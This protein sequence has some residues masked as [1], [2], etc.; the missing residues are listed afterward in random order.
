MND[1]II[2]SEQQLYGFYSVN[3]EYFSLGSD[4]NFLQIMG[5]SDND[6]LS[7]NNLYLYHADEEK[8][9][10]ALD[11]CE[12]TNGSAKSVCG[13]SESE[14]EIQAD[15]SLQPQETG[16]IG[17]QFNYLWQ[18]GQFHLKSDTAE[19]H[20]LLGEI[21]YPEDEYEQLFAKN[22]YKAANPLTFYTDTALEQPAFTA[23]RNHTLNL[24]N[25]KVTDDQFYLQ[26]EKD[27]TTGWQR[28]NS[29]EY[30]YDFDS[31]LP[32]SETGWF[33]GVY[34]RLAG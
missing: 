1:K 27:G 21:S 34:D 15:L 12:E 25:I 33:Y 8:L 3:I 9:V 32:P 19:V 6:Y 26:F 11:L 7:F 30:I 28:V 18:D 16:R 29:A 13:V 4:L 23:D 20:S 31:D 17:W 2:L 5:V 14:D 10:K 22:Q 24:L